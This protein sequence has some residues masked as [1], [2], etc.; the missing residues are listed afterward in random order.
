MPLHQFMLTTSS[1]GQGAPAPSTAALGTGGLFGAPAAATTTSAF[2]AG[3]SAFGT[4]APAAGGLF[5]ATAGEKRSGHIC[6][7]YVFFV[8]RMPP[9]QRSVVSSP[10]TPSFL[11]HGLVLYSFSLRGSRCN[12]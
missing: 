9:F 6:L 12:F 5:G 4:P 1:L 11:V 10:R 7:S 3:A 2:G 8:A